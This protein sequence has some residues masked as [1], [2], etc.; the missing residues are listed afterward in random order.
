MISMPL[1]ASID[2]TRAIESSNGDEKFTVKY[3]LRL[4]IKN[5]FLHRFIK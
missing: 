3:I 4:F 5:S 2:N 1:T